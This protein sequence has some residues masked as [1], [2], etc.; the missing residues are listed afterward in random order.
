MKV[1]K[2]CQIVRF[3]LFIHRWKLRSLGTL[4]RSHQ[5]SGALTKK[6]PP[7]GYLAVYVGMQEKRFWIPTRFLNMPVFV[8]LLKKTEEEFGFKC[9]GGLVLLCEVEFFEEVLRLLDKDE[10]RFGRF[11]LEDYF[12]IVSCE[13]GFDSCKETTYV[14]TPLLEK[15]RCL[16]GFNEMLLKLFPSSLMS[17]V[18]LASRL[19]FVLMMPKLIS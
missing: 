11:G 5:K 9:N 19:Q 18:F 7:A 6:T 12:K 2:I 13:V 16:M 15:A 4:R 14:F 3:K 17:G 8:G 1:N 10:T